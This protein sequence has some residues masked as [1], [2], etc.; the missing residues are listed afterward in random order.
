[1]NSQ[2]SASKPQLINDYQALGQQ[3]RI[4]GFTLIELLAV[5]FIIGLVVS[6]VSFTVIGEDPQD[7]I[8]EQT[9]RLQVIFDMASDYAVLNQM[10]LGLRIDDKEMSYEFV[11][12]DDEQKWSPIDT[13]AIFSKTQLPEHVTLELTLEGLEWQSEDSLFDSRIFDETLSVSEDSVQIG[14]EEDIE[15]EPPQVLILSSGEITPF[16]L[17]LIFDEPFSNDPPFFF[18]LQGDEVPPLTR[19]GPE[20]L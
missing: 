1:M 14:N 18:A 6:L 17:R 16:E 7:K 19:V 4:K 3:K 10:Q 13:Q 11:A 15:P 9:R 12:L 5:I 20:P 8:E 2:L